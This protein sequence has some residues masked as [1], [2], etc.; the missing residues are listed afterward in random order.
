MSNL[1]NISVGQCEIEVITG[2]KPYRGEPLK[3]RMEWGQRVKLNK[4][5]DYV[6]YCQVHLSSAAATTSSKCSNRNLKMPRIQ[7]F[8]S[9][10]K[11]KLLK[12]HSPQFL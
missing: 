7:V 12:R 2:T 11:M 6:F 5:S 10:I 3:G 1:A 8:G 4:D 9:A